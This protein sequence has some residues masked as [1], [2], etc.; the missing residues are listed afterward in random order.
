MLMWTDP[1]LAGMH[2]MSVHAMQAIL[3]DWRV[4]R[5]LSWALNEYSRN[6]LNCNKGLGP[7]AACCQSRLQGADDY[8]HQR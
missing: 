5:D 3:G 8:D 7:D 2:H 4:D 1:K 6:W